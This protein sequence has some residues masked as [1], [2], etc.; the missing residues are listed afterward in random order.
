[1]W[2]ELSLQHQEIIKSAANETFSSGGPSGS[3]RTP[4]R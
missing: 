4:M 2:K 3:A 1:M